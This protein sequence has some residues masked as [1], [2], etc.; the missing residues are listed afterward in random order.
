MFYS[1]PLAT[2]I[3]KTCHETDTTYVLPPYTT[4][5]A[6]VFALS[7]INDVWLCGL[8][9]LQS[10]NAVPYTLV[11]QSVRKTRFHDQI[12][13]T[14]INRRLSA[15]QIVHCSTALLNV[16]SNSYLTIATILPISVMASTI[17]S[18]G[19]FSF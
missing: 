16:S 13:F 6:F 10:L 11:V 15:Y 7:A 1:L 2:E 14:R 5:D 19:K 12:L 18:G 8:Q 3:V 4:S 17:L 9:T